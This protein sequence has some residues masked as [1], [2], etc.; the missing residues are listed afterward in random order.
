M[1]MKKI[2]KSVGIYFSAFLVFLLMIFPLYSVFLTSVQREADIRTKDI[3]FIP[4]YITLEHYRAIFAPGHIVKINEAILNSGFVSVAAALI[5]VTLGVMAAYAV[6]RNRLKY[7]NIVLFMMSSI[8]ILP[9][10][11]FILP[12]YVLVVKI[13]WADRYSTLIL[14]YTAFVLPFVIW[15]LKAFVE[16]IPIEIEEAARVDGCT[17]FE[18]FTKIYLPLMK[19][20]IGASLLFAFVLSWIEF[21][22]PLIFTGKI[23]MMTVELGLYRS[24]ID[25]QIGQLAAAAMVTMIPVLL[26]TT[27]F[28]GLIIQVIMGTEK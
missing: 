21:L 20:G 10:I 8:Y 24:T 9:T 11:L 28:S 12:L 1:N 13:G 22:T 26:V 23:K 2:A 7:G 14:L 4:K 16:A 25:I 19:P 6:S 18:I 3:S 5:A 15:V 27:V 17:S